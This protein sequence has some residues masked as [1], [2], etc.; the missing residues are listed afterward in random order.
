MFDG[1]TAPLIETIEDRTVDGYLRWSLFDVFARLAFDGALSREAALKLID[2][3]DRE[4]LADDE[5]A[6]WE[7]WQDVIQ[8]LGIEERADRVRTSWED[9]RNPHRESISRTGRTS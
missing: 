5:D 1:D 7:G 9:G 3:F 8:L 2:R 4:R 6:A